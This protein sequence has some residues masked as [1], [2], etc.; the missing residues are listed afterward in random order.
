[1]ANILLVGGAGG[2]GAA[3]AQELVRRGDMVTATVR[4]KEGIHPLRQKIPGLA[5]VLALDLSKAD[6]I[7]S[8][9]D[10][11]LAEK[12]DMDAVVVCAADNSHAPLE[13]SS[14]SDFRRMLEINA[15][16]SLAIYQAMLPRLRRTKGRLIFVSSFS[17]KVAIPLHGIYQ[18]SKFALEALA[19]TMRLETASSGVKIVLMLPG[20]IETAMFTKA[21]E[22]LPAMLA[23]L[24][25]QSKAHYGKFY[26]GLLAG[27]EDRSALMQPG[28]V[29][30][31]VI[32]ALDAPD[33]EPRY[34]VGTGA[35]F[36]MNRRQGLSDRALDAMIGE[37]FKVDPV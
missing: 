36:F 32:S 8:V 17:G 27:L 9:L 3:L 29:A 10:A 2:V 22:N 28:E 23:M 35:Q 31:A 1:M 30:H 25:E 34:I 11:A 14:L 26:R 37:I 20:G 7:G 19:D 13:L 24:D 5:D 21:R 12:E 16:A 33:P 4:A 15:V 18:S 6:M